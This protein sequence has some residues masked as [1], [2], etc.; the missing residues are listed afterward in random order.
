MEEK[1]KR[2]VFGTLIA[3]MLVAA[4]A[5]PVLAATEQE[6]TASVTVNQVISIS[7]TDAGSG[8]INFGPVTPPVTGQGDVAQSSGTPAIKVVVAPE[9][10]VAIDINIKGATTSALAL[11]NWKYSDTFAG[12][13]TALT[14]SFVQVYDEKAAGSYDVYH[15]IDVP[16]STA[17]GTHTATVT[18]QAIAD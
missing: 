6:T 12:A 14:T 8:G 7:L 9:T 11:A 17:S 13:K 15:W 18:Y 4:V 5:T 3:L 10:N 1:V 16:T 2:F